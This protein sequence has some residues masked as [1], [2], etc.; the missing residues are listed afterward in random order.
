MRPGPDHG[1]LAKPGG[2]R[3]RLG[4]AVRAADEDRH[5]V[6]KPV[7]CIVLDKPAYG[8]AGFRQRPFGVRAVG[9]AGA[10][11]SR[12]EQ[13]TGHGRQPP[14]RRQVQRHL[15]VK[16]QDWRIF[17]AGCEQ[18]L[19]VCV[20]NHHAPPVPRRRETGT[21]GHNVI[22][23]WRQAPMTGHIHPGRRSAFL[24]PAGTVLHQGVRGRREHALVTVP[25]AD[26]I[27]CRA[28]GDHGISSGQR[29]VRTAGQGPWSIPSPR[30]S[31]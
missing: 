30:R 20:G 4:Q 9:P 13:L 29:A 19:D 7:A 11:R 31:A 25:P 22:S 17:A 12:V 16:R 21:A 2:Q 10:A 27:R 8:L 14:Q 6:A 3:D 28:I 5:A 18:L 1:L 15:Q 23:A 24:P 26:Q